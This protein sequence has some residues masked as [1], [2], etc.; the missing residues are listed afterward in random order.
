MNFDLS[1]VGKTTFSQFTK[2]FQNWMNYS[3][4]SKR[5]VI[6][7]GHSLGGALA[8]RL[9]AHQLSGSVDVKE[10]A[11]EHLETFVFNSP[12]LDSQTSKL[13]EN[14]PRLYH[15]RNHG[16]FVPLVHKS[17]PTEHE[18]IHDFSTRHNLGP[19]QR[20]VIHN[21]PGL[22][23]LESKGIKLEL[24]SSNLVKRIKSRNFKPFK[25]SANLRLARF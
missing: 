9:H 15:I 3:R 14:H 2:K 25:A 20:I 6:L 23:S 12:A 5:K 4:K 8:M 1:G 7:C 16:D 21:Y 24:D 17:P 22:A 10:W 19:R 11:N 13:L 18:Y